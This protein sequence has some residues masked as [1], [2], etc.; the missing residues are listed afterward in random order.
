MT[1]IFSMSL[2]DNG[3]WSS[4]LFCFLGSSRAVPPSPRWAIQEKQVRHLPAPSCTKPRKSRLKMKD[5]CSKAK[6]R[7]PEEMGNRSLWLGFATSNLSSKLK[8]RVCTTQLLNSFARDVANKSSH[9]CMPQIKIWMNLPNLPST[10]TQGWC[11]LA[12]ALNKKRECQPV[13]PLRPSQQ[14]ED[15]EPSKWLRAHSNRD[16]SAFVLQTQPSDL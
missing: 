2:C 1:F 15:K 14:F 12:K 9:S 13:P 6:T 4:I 3:I 5:K 10:R 16:G 11:L 7:Q 8:D